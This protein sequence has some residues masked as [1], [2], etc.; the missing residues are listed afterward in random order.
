MLKATSQDERDSLYGSAMM[1]SIAIAAANDLIPEGATTFDDIKASSL[2]PILNNISVGIVGTKLLMSYFVPASPQVYTDNVTA[3][4][5]AH[6]LPSMRAAFLELVQRYSES[7]VPAENMNPL[8]AA[9][10][11]WYSLHPEGNLMPFTVSQTKDKDTVANLA[12]VQATDKMVSWYRDNKSLWKKYPNEAPEAALWLAPRDGEFD[13]AAWQLAT[14]ELGLKEGKDFKNFATDVLASK[15]QFE[16]FATIDDYAQ[17]IALQDPR[18]TEGRAEIARLEEARKKD[19]ATVE[20]GNPFFADKNSEKNFDKKDRHAQVAFDKVKVMVSDMYK[21][22]EAT[23]TSNALY[24][25]ILTYEDYM[26][27]I[28]MITGTTNADDQS[29]RELRYSLQ[30]D[31]AVLG[32]ENA[33]VQQFVTAVLNRQPDF[34]ALTTATGGMN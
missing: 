5:R 30:R 27:D 7:D 31:L 10:S 32:E 17:D 34:V 11:K 33:N 9:M 29:K 25:A 21:K 23:D 2:W 19:L 18:T 16:Y 24:S 4:A 13:W 1:D 12:N 22:G 15:T 28:K 20:A 6:G 8:G 3:F 26:A 14:N